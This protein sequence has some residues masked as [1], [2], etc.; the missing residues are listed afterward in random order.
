M[1]NRPD[2]EKMAAEYT[3]ELLRV[4]VNQARNGDIEKIERHLAGMLQSSFDL[5]QAA[6]NGWVFNMDEA[7][8]NKRV[9]VSYQWQHDNGSI[10]QYWVPATYY[11]RFTL[12][13][14]EDAKREDGDWHEPSGTYYAKKGWYLDEDDEGMCLPIGFEPLAFCPI[15]LPTKEQ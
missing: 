12:P 3:P 1:K 11:E 14:H 7:P 2:F 10:R 8:K 6:F 13:M 5:G 4:L 15:T 9:L